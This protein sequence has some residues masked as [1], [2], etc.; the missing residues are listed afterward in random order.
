MNRLLAGVAALTALAA[1][2]ADETLEDVPFV[3]DYQGVQTELLA[4]DLVRVRVR[5]EGARNDE[6]V[7]DYAECAIAQYTLIRGFRFARHVRTT[8]ILRGGIRTADTVYTVSPTM[9]RG[10]KTIDAEV[11][12]AD[13]GDRGIPTV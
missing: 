5:M 11:K 12:V 2:A 9:P 7:I 3:P 1:C 10:L 6:D 13:C 8:V 4:D